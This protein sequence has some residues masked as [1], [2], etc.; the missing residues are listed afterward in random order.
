MKT[1]FYLQDVLVEPARLRLS[2][3][4]GTVEV[5]PRVMDVIVGLAADGDAVVARAVLLERV[6]GA[7]QVGYHALARAIHEARKSLSVV[8]PGQS[9]I[10]TIP[11]RGYRLRVVPRIAEVTSL[12]PTPP[13]VPSPSRPLPMRRM[14]VRVG[15]T[16]TVIVAL[17]LVMHAFEMHGSAVH[18][19]SVAAIL[20]A[21][22]AP[23][24]RTAARHG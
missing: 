10:E 24:I 12:A 20:I 11:Q 6:W 8:A 5:Q 13:A 16:M 4:A 1:D 22:V 17:G 15:V 21:A 23:D 3:A 7:T 9:F 2:S 18:L 19:V 14:P